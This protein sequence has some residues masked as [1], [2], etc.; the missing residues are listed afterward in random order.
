MRSTS[1]FTPS[2]VAMGSAAVAGGITAAESRLR[3]NIAALRQRARNRAASVRARNSFNLLHTKPQRR[4]VA[5]DQR[6]APPS[7]VCSPNTR[8]RPASRFSI[9]RVEFT[10]SSLDSLPRC[11]AATPS[12]CDAAIA[13]HRRARTSA[14][15]ARALHEL[16]RTQSRRI[17]SGTFRICSRAAHNRRRPPPALAASR[18]LH[19]HAKRNA[20]VRAGQASRRGFPPR[21]WRVHRELAPLRP[22]ILPN[23]RASPVGPPKTRLSQTR[24]RG[25]WPARFRALVQLKQGRVLL[26]ITRSGPRCLAESWADADRRGA[27]FPPPNPSGRTRAVDRIGVVAARF[28]LAAAAAQ[29][30]LTPARPPSRAP[31]AARSAPLRVALRGGSHPGPRP[32]RWRGGSRRRRASFAGVLSSLGSV[33]REIRAT[34]SREPPAA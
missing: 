23:A 18:R 5:D 12:S 32:A 22:P 33:R 10:S 6:I 7:R 26:R 2:V 29:A 16:A 15:S 17:C 13:A 11:R 1:I 19:R 27:T 30:P 34:S 9:S 3:R 4:I 20:I 21:E 31:R 25:S 28:P 8:V 24:A 14:A